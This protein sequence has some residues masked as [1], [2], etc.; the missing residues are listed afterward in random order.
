MSFGGLT[1]IKLGRFWIALAVSVVFGFVTSGV[2]YAAPITVTN[3]IILD[4]LMSTGG[5]LRLG[6]DI[7]LN[8]T[9]TINNDTSLDLNGHTLSF[10][11]VPADPDGKLQ[12]AITSYADFVV[13]DSS[14]GQTGKITSSLDFTV[15][16]GDSRNFGK[17]TLQSGTIDC[18]GA[19]CVYNLSESEINGGKISGK[20][21]SFYLGKNS[22]AVMNNGEIISSGDPTVR[23]STGA[24]FT[25]NDGLI[26]IGNNG[27]AI[28]VAGAGSSFTMNDGKIDAS[29]S[30]GF[31]ATG[32][33]GFLD[34]EV[35]INGGVI[36]AHSY[37]I[38]GNGSGAESQSDGRNAKIT[39]NGG[40]LSSVAAAVIY[41]PQVN[42][43][44][45]ITGGMLTGGMSAVEMR[46]GKLVVS[47]GTLIGNKNRYDVIKNDSGNTTTGAAIAVALHNT[48]Q[49][50]EVIVTGGTFDAHTP[51]SHANP[52]GNSPEDL[53]K[54][55][56]NISGGEF[57]G[58][59]DG[60]TIVNVADTPFISGGIYNF[61]VTDYVL[62]GYEE[63]T[64]SDGRIEV[65][66]IQDDEPVVVPET[67]EPGVPDTGLDTKNV[68]ANA[69]RTNLRILSVI[70]GVIS[71]AF[72]VILKVVYH[73]IEKRGK[74]KANVVIFWK[75][76]QA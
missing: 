42:G 20:D 29:N 76:K 9:V 55:S 54:I 2:V 39:V 43:V 58:V 17:L 70:V 63:V 25:M 71:V 31:G 11:N 24:T 69:R 16:T 75:E 19:Y 34:S 53:A 36:D 10:E 35:V 65:R 57:F 62:D 8:K 21:F 15:Q 66:A 12:S 22:R 51:F 61:A 73:N 1:K 7:V 46:A 40:E 68:I 14:A 28:I 32:V 38:C 74:G 30:D 67:N 50:I 60:A 6:S 56:F 41:A 33:A 3:P 13:M 48:K 49:P 59:G 5:E 47:G 23:V 52:Q 72:G 44:T 26:Q 64:L 27:V 4:A 37:A 18:A 45:T